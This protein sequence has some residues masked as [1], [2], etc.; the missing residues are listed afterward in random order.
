MRLLVEGTFTCIVWPGLLQRC[1]TRSPRKSLE[2]RTLGKV[3]ARVS[4]GKKHLLCLFA[5]HHI[6]ISKGNSFQN[7]NC[8]NFRSHRV[9]KALFL[10][11]RLLRRKREEKGRTG[12]FRSTCL[13]MFLSTLPSSLL[14]IFL[15][16]STLQ[17]ARP[18]ANA[19]V[20]S[21]PSLLVEFS[22]EGWIFV[23]L[24]NEYPA[25]QFIH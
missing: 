9:R 23:L 7:L 25:S 16:S 18:I 24:I 1:L 8:N 15:G 13:S 3:W 19:H 5:L 2:R 20:A 12:T 22:P 14:W 21:P 17:P 4:V 10:P 11:F 6:N